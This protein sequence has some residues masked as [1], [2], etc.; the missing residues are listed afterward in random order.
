MPEISIEVSDIIVDC[1][2]PERLAQFWSAV[3]GRQAGPKNGAY[4]ALERFADR[5]LGIAFQK[6]P[7]PT[8]GKN[9]VHF[10][11]S[12]SD[13]AATASLVIELG[14]CRLPGYEDGGFLVM[15]DPEGNEFCIVT[16]DPIQLDPEGR[17]H[18]ADHID[19]GR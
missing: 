3:L 8:P 10:D 5:R 9:R 12:S 4:I 6:V 19:I 13:P 15:A 14:G 16:F 1:Q 18:Y 17:T 7:G 2:S 11:V